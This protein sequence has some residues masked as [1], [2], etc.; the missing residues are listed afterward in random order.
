MAK[1]A[2]VLLHGPHHDNSLK[3]YFKEIVFSMSANNNYAASFNTT[4]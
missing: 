4:E 2:L 1:G 3:I